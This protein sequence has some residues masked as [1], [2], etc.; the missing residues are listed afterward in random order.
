MYGA[1]AVGMRFGGCKLGARFSWCA[2]S[3]SLSRAP[4]DWMIWLRS[5]RDLNSKRTAVAG[6]FF[7]L[8]EFSCASLP[9]QTSSWSA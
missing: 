5:Q 2:A 1:G 6:A 8:L 4:S 9:P 7:Q 3:S